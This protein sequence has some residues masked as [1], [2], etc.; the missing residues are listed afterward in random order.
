M[1]PTSRRVEVSSVNSGT[2]VVRRGYLEH[3]AYFGELSLL[4]SRKRHA[5][6][7]AVTYCE[8]LLLLSD[9]YRKVANLYLSDAQRVQ[10]NAEQMLETKKRFKLG[11]ANG[12]GTGKTLKKALGP[13]RDSFYNLP[14][15]V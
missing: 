12:R 14:V 4:F 13:G 5:T 6:I 11:G 15:R 1:G 9:E 8:V 7:V 2:G 10:Q 3:G